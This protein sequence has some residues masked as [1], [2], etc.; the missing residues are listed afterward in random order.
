MSSSFPTR[1]GDTRVNS[2]VAAL[3]F[4]CVVGVR[5]LRPSPARTS[6]EHARAPDPMRCDTRVARHMSATL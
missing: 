5:V 1:L 3:I 2:A 6:R 4:I